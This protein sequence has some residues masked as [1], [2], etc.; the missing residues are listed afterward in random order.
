MSKCK[1]CGAEIIWAKTAKGKKMPFDA[2]PKKVWVV[3]HLG[4]AF[5]SD[6][7]TPHWATCPDAN[8]HRKVQ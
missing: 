2:I 3:T 8:K 4:D 6:S 5:L 7:Y 1:S